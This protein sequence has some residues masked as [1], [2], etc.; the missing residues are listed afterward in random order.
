[1]MQEDGYSSGVSMLVGNLI[2]EWESRMINENLA[3]G[4]G[5]RRLNHY[6]IIKNMMG[7]IMEEMVG[8]WNYSRSSVL[9]AK[10]K[11]IELDTKLN[12]WDATLAWNRLA[13]GLCTLGE[14]GSGNVTRA[15]MILVDRG[16]VPAMPLSSS[17][18]FLTPSTITQ[19]HNKRVHDIEVSIHKTSP[20]PLK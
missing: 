18:S 4:I 2:D 3:R 11:L 12:R 10:T 6:W 8:T 16:L 14:G 13:L 20:L 17:V 9:E 15:P 7:F 5:G 19:L 1:M